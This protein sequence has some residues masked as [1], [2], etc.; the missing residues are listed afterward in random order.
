MGSDGGR[1]SYGGEREWCRGLERGS[2]PGLIVACVRS[3]L[4]MAACCFPCPHIVACVC[5]SWPVSA[6]CCLCSCVVPCVRTLLLISMHCCPC[7]HMLPM[8]CT[9]FPTSVH[10]H[11][12]SFS[13]M[14]MGGS[15]HSWTVV[16]IQGHLSLF[17]GKGRVWWWGAVGWWW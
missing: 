11:G 16:F 3:L 17:M 2:P 1:G 7:P 14:S 13:F 8:V 9:S 4:P 12:Q 10:V 5:A 15:L 6:C